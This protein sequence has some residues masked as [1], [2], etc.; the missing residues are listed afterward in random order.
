MNKRIGEL[1][2]QAGRIPMLDCIDRET[3]DRITTFI[4]SEE[5][6]N[7]FAELI[8]QECKDTLLFHG[9]DEAVPYIEW[10]AKNHFGV[11]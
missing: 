9:F 5:S 1:A 6:M 3:G 10:M 11:E 7:K 2:E 8:V 4:F